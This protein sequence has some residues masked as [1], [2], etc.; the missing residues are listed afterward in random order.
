MKIVTSGSS[1]L[2]I[3]AYACCIAYTELQNSLGIPT[4]AVSSAPLNYSISDS[5]LSF[6][7]KILNPKSLIIDRESEFIVMDVS[8]P[9]FFDPIVDIERITHIY[10]HHVG[11]EDMWHEKLGDDAKIEFIGCAATL[12]YEEWEKAGM[13]SKMTPETAMILTAAILDN[14]LNFLAK[15]TTSRDIR[16]KDRLCVLAGISQDWCEAYFKECQEA[17]ERDLI[18]SI[19]KDA[20]T[21]C[22]V[23]GLP[24]AIGQIVVWDAKML[25]LKRGDIYTALNALASCW[26][27]NIVCLGTRRGYFLCNEKGSQRKLQTIFDIEFEGDIAITKKPVLRK[28]IIKMALEHE[29][30][31]YKEDLK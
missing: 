4:V 16:A 25:L 1:Y 10:D 17:V 21:D 18:S 31:L 29:N 26:V 12:I 11:F 28:E 15:V 3:D 20:K 5:I 24:K 30:R 22:N 14:T 27:L 19:R 2:D 6:E 23:F 13:L 9:R 7:Q 8:D